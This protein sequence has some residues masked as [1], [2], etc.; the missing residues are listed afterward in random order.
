MDKPTLP[1][2]TEWET[3]QCLQD[4]GHRVAAT[5]AYRY[6]ARRIEADDDYP[7]PDGAEA[8]IAMAA[9]AM[10]SLDRLHAGVAVTV[11]AMQPASAARTPTRR[12]ASVLSEPTRC[13]ARC[14]SP[15]PSLRASK[16]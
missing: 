15:R 1:W 12:P 4:R 13:T 3:R 6:I 14:G 10:A 9:A 5:E 7:L 11:A 2:R 8:V 16:P